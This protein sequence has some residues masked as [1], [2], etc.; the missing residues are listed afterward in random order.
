[1]STYD[2]ELERIVR[3][4]NE[5]VAVAVAPESLQAPLVVEPDSE[6]SA[7]PASEASSTLDQ[8]LRYSAERGASDILLVA[9]SGLVLRIHGAISQRRGPAFSDEDLRSLMLPLLS[10]QG[11]RDLETERSVDFSFVRQGIG[12][13]RANIHF[14]RGSLGASIRILPSE[15]PTLESL[16]LPASLAKLTERKQGLVLVTGPAGSGKTTTLAALIGILNRNYP[17]HVVTIED[18]IEY[19]HANDRSVIE[20]MEIGRDAKTFAGALRSILRQSPDVIL[21]GEMRDPETM[22]AALTAAETGHI[23]FSTLHTNDTIQAIGR[24][25]DGFPAGQQNQ[26]RQ[27]LSLGLLAIIAQQLVPA[28]DGARRYP[29]LEIL[30]ANTAVRNLIRKGEDH[31]LRS[32]LSMGR[33][34]GMMM[35][36]ESLN[37]LVRAERI[38]YETAAAHCFRPDELQRYASR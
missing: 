32:Q 34:E 11:R 30:I 21:V 36:E 31:M 12:R 19:H 26:I 14:Q 38:A 3:E 22:A 16:H 15:I 37:E 18:P 2:P 1:M 4:L 20:Q 29:A 35:M 17:Y 24:V 13:F 28:A 27:Q 6:L 8:L 10:P 9:G 23:V 7:L 25:V 33:S 5:K